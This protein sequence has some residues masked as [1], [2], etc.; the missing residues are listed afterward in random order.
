MLDDVEIVG[1]LANLE[2]AVAELQNRL[3]API[4]SDWLEQLT[5]SIS[6]AQAFETALQYGREIRC[7]D[8]PGS[9]AAPG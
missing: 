8:K 6:D 3:S 1:R 9:D 4:A 2:R 5:G 7:T